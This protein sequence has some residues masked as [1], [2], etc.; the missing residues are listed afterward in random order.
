MKTLI[1]AMIASPDGFAVV[2][3][4]AKIIY[5]NP[6]LERI[7]GISE[8]EAKTSNIWQLQARLMVAPNT[9]NNIATVCSYWQNQALAD[10][11]EKKNFQPSE[12]T[13]VRADATKAIIRIH[14]RPFR[15]KTSNYFLVFV[16]DITETFNAFQAAE[17]SLQLMRHDFISPLNAISGFSSPEIIADANP[18]EIQGYLK[19]IHAHAQKMAKM[20]QL[21]LLLARIERSKYKLKKE[22]IGL[23]SLLE[24]AKID[25]QIFAKDLHVNLTVRFDH[26]F[27]ITQK[28]IEIKADEI[29]LG[30][31]LNNLLRNAAEATPSDESEITLTVSWAEDKLLL[32]IHNFGEVPEKMKGRLFQKFASSGKE[33]GNGL[34]LHSAKLIALAHGGEIYCHSANGE[35]CFTVEIPLD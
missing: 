13:I 16:T 6:A 15:D 19:I 9:H 10:L 8:A 35:T 27:R 24:N 25:F 12:Q 26:K 30:S 14:Y 1:T 28:H 21:Y 3:D 2:N 4:K 32:K 20:S 5:W 18:E 33:N 17:T 23:I 7:T 22:K 31:L 11:A 29:L 34:G